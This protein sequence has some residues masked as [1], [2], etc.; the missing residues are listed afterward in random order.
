MKESTAA[1]DELLYSLLD[2]SRLDAGVINI[3][4]PMI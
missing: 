1:M 4:D 3:V 2:I